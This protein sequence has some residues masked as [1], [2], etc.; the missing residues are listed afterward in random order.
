MNF[1]LQVKKY[2]DDHAI[3]Q[4]ILDDFK[5][6]W[7]GRQIVYPIFNTSGKI[8]FHIYRQFN[9]EPRFLYQKGSHVS[10]YGIHKIQKEKTIVITEGLT[11]CLCCWSHGIPSVTSTGGALSFQKEWKDLLCDKEIIICLDSDQTGQ[12]GTAKILDIFPKAKVILLSDKFKDLSD[13]IFN[14]ANINDLIVSAKTFSNIEEVKDD[15]ANRLALW[16][17]TWFHTAYIE[18]HREKKIIKLPKRQYGD[19]LTRAKSYP[20]DQLIKFG[21]DN[22]ACCIFHEETGASMHYYKN[23]NRFFCYGC[24]KGGDVLDIYQKLNNCSL[25]EAIKNLQ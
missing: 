5:V 9:N 3:S 14:G 24:S 15:M 4:K 19:E 13:H 8:I 7:N 10:L 6:E 2:F 11:D 1:P 25:S 16:Q 22:K 20:I 21:R 12:K 18:N 17:S 23:K